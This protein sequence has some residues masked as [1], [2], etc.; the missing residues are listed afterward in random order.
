MSTE[1]APEASTR[2]RVDVPAF[3]EYV[4]AEIGVDEDARIANAVLARA[5]ASASARD[6]DIDAD[7]ELLWAP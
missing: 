7:A 6:G 3:V 5:E 4:R 1:P 2:L